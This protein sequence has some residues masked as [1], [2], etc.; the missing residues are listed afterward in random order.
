MRRSI[1]QS[2]P[3]QLGF[4]ALSM[5]GPYPLVTET[6]RDLFSYK[7]SVYMSGLRVRFSQSFYLPR[8]VCKIDIGHR[9]CSFKEKSQL[10]NRTFKLSL[11][12]V[13]LHVRFMLLRFH[14]AI[15]T[16]N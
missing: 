5:A 3:P 15:F 7:G 4:P 16:L 11:T 9:K 13:R 10:K 8:L 2:F 1:V 12:L 14:N 6:M